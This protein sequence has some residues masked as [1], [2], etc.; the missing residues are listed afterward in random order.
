MYCGSV[1]LLCRL[2]APEAEVP[3]GAVFSVVEA[4]RAAV[5]EAV[6][7]VA[8]VRT[9]FLHFLLGLKVNWGHSIGT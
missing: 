5:P 1:E 4:R 9:S 2:G 8:Q 7:A 3:G 6:R